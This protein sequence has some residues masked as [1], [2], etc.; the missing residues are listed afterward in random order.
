[1]LHFCIVY[2]FEVFYSRPPGPKPCP[3]SILDASLPLIFTS[4]LR[5]QIK[6]RIILQYG[7]LISIYLLLTW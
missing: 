3:V 1:M 5:M 4:R 6:I 7:R 2:L